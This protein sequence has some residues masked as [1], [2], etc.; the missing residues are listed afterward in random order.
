MVVMRAGQD[1]NLIGEI[2]TAEIIYQNCDDHV[3]KQ[4]RAVLRMV[5]KMR[6][7]VIIHF[8]LA[9]RSFSLTAKNPMKRWDGRTSKRHSVAVLLSDCGRYLGS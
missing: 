2:L 8:N 6:I 1:A 5:M 4:D 7:T 9:G 3:T